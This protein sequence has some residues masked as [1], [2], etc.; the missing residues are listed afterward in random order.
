MS[1]EDRLNAI[2]RLRAYGLIEEFRPNC[3]RLKDGDGYRAS[4]IGFET[5]LEQY[6]IHKNITAETINVF[7]NSNNNIV[8]QS[9]LDNAFD[10]PITQNISPNIEITPPKR[11]WLE[12]V[13]WISGIILFLMGVY[14]FVLKHIFASSNS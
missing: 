3:W 14:E 11:S 1:G 9:S 8:N 4:E 5:W 7:S 6:R 2:D 13:A 10:S 12:I